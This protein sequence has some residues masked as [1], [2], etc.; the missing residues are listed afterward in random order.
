MSPAFSASIRPAFF[1]VIRAERS[2][3]LQEPWTELTD[4]VVTPAVPGQLDLLKYRFD[5]TAG[6]AR[7][8]VRFRV[9]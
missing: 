8:F 5:I 3:T 6:T 9:E 7:R 1:S 2:D 4:P